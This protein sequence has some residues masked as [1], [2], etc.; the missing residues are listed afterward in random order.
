MIRSPSSAAFCLCTGYLIYKSM[1]MPRL[2]GVAMVLAGLGL[3]LNAYS[4][5][6]IPNFAH[7][8]SPTGFAL[9]GIGELSLTLWLIA[10]GVNGRRWHEMKLPPEKRTGAT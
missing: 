8:L 10:I 6:L 4:P 1:F 9:D 3:L 2:I 7:Q 5:L